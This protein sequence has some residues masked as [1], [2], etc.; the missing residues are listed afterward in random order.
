MVANFLHTKFTF[1]YIYIIFMLHF[2]KNEDEVKM[3]ISSG[4]A[5]LEASLYTKNEPGKK[6]YELLKQ[7]KAMK[8]KFN[9]DGTKLYANYD[10]NFNLVDDTTQFTSL[11]CD[12]YYIFANKDFLAISIAQINDFNDLDGIVIGKLISSPEFILE[13][14]SSLSMS[15]MLTSSADLVLALDEESTPN[16]NIDLLFLIISIIIIILLIVCLLSF[17]TK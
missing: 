1:V 15:L 7:E 11:N 4:D 17:L 9:A 3:T 10:E 2:V 12:A 6:L 16:F 5:K 13:F 8:L 14:F